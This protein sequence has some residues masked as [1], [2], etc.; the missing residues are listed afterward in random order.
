MY[1]SL[2][3]KF[4]LNLRKAF[5]T[6]NRE[7]LLYKLSHYKLSGCF[8]NILK[9]M[10]DEVKYS[11]KFTEG[12]T[13]S[14]SSK[15]GV[16]Q[17]CVLTP[18][19]FPLY[20]NDMVK[21]FDN[22]CDP[23]TINNINVSCL[24]YADD[25]VLISESAKGI[26]NCLNKLSNYCDIWNLSV[27]IDKSKVIIFNKSGRVIKK[28]NFKYMEY[29]LEITQEY[30]Y[31]GVLFKS[32]GSFT[33]ANV[34]LCQKARKALFCIYKTLFSDKLNILPNLKLFDSCVNPILL[35]CSEILCLDT[36]L[37]DNV[38]VTRLHNIYCRLQRIISRNG[39]FFLPESRNV[40]ILLYLP[41]PCSLRFSECLVGDR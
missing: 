22:I 11:I 40:V 37:K 38:T 3:F 4:E 9:N 6:V 16:K 31:L 36:L 5:D 33:K 30:K 39:G 1:H 35:Y 12:E 19:L 17:G 20:L 21:I 18:K 28:D 27:N 13:S 34:Y 41:V 29:V 23:I 8:F 15:I 25:I 10:Y 26:Q 7:A 14:V 2:T 32:S 24:M